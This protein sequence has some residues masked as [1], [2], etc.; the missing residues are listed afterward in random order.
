MEK[1]NLLIHGNLIIDGDFAI[2]PLVNVIT[3]VNPSDYDL[4]NC[5]EMHGDVRI[6]ANNDMPGNMKGEVGITGDFTFFFLGK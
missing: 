2:F 6:K 5:I 3:E 4:S 1:L